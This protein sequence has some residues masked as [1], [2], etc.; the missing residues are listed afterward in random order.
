MSALR[1]FAAGPPTLLSAT[2][3]LRPQ[4][5]VVRCRKKVMRV[6]DAVEV[7][8]GASWVAASDV[9]S[10]G[11][12]RT[13]VKTGCWMTPATATSHTRT[14]SFSVFKVEILRWGDC[15]CTLGPLSVHVG[16]LLT[17]VVYSV[18]L[19]S[20]FAFLCVPWNFE[21]GEC[22]WPEIGGG[23]TVLLHFNLWASWF[24]SWIVSRISTQLKFI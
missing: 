11:R 17:V 4:D 3:S 23:G 5:D 18:P 16:P 19:R 10:P 2:C 15:T 12:C 13:L 20:P 22:L 21:V 7:S 8:L 14:A 1:Q 9:C 24:T 6:D